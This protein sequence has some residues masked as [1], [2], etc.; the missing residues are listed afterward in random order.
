M[1]QSVWL[2]FGD[3]GLLV[4]ASVL[5]FKMVM[6]LAIFRLHQDYDK[7]YVPK[8]KRPP[9]RLYCLIQPLI[10]AGQWTWKQIDTFVQ[11]LKVT[12]RRRRCPWVCK[13]IH[14]KSKRKGSLMGDVVAYTT[15]LSAQKVSPTSKSMASSTRRAISSRQIVSLNQLKS[16]TAG[17]IAQ[18]KG[19]LTTQR[20]RYA[21]VF[22]DQHSQYAYVYLQWTI[23]SAKTVQAKHSFERMAKDMGIRIHHYHAYDGRFADMGFVHDCQKQYQGITYCRVNA[24]FQNGIAEKKIR[25]LQEQTRTLML[26]AVHKW[27]S[28]LSVHLWPYGLHTVN[29]IHNSTLHKGSNVPPIELFSGVEVRPKRK[30][31]HAFGCPTYILNKNL[32]AQ[33]NLPKWQSRARFGVYLGPSPN[34]SRSMSLVLNPPTL[35]TRLT[36]NCLFSP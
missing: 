23:T 2:F 12:N 16:S 22:V 24:H 32:Q 11:G 31:Y 17:F 30:H 19:K 8:R 27:S 34:Y 28:M 18:L 25:D 14:I 5:V 7:P 36:L 13:S 29:D 21:T 10:P 6:L 3:V 20:Y 35:Q 33:M 4:V 9:R 26:H 15:Q 1:P